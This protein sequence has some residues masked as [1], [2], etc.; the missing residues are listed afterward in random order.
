MVSEIQGSN[1]GIVQSTNNN[2][3]QISPKKTDEAKRTEAS[4]SVA[5]SS[6]NLTQTASSLQALEKSIAAAPEIDQ[7]KVDAV[8]K[9]ISEGTYKVDS[10]RTATKLIDF[11]TALPKQS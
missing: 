2:N 8:R 10:E 7:Q 3:S 9:A 4:A 11:D 6:V 5:S 1:S